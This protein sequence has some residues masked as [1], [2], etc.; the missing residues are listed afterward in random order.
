MILFVVNDAGPAKYIAYLIKK[1][2]KREYICLASDI[3]AKVFDDFGIEYYRDNIDI[4]KIELIITGT[5]LNSCLDKRWVQ[6]GK[7]HGIRTISIIE[8][9][10]LYKKRFELDGKY[11]FAD[12]IL[13]NDKIAYQEAID[14]GVDKERLQIVG[15]PVF[16]NIKKKRYRQNEKIEWKKFYKLDNRKI[17][18]FISEEFKKDFPKDLDNY[19]GFDEFE[20]LNDIIEFLDEDWI[21]LIKLHPSENISKYKYLEKFK[22]IVIIEKTDIDKLILFSDIFI[23]MGSMLLLEASLLR[24]NVYSYRPNELIEFIG[25]KNGMT[26]EIKD[27]K[28]LKD[29]LYG[30]FKSRTQMVKNNFIGSTDNIV[31]LIEEIIK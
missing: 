9:W 29:V 1:L 2:D 3:S 27:K 19:F 31:K 24:D 10:S 6:I 5:C 4:S 30:E 23:G 14:D 25:N 16:E 21:L 7:K 15:N 20:V 17:I 26:I 12:T 22:N 18:T 13:V 11:I 28:E 8:H